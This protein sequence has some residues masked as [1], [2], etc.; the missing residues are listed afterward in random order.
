MQNFINENFMLQT[1]SAQKLY[2]DYAVNEPIFDYHCHLSPK[3]IYENP[4]YENLTELWLL[5]DHY[6][7]RLM[8]ACGISEEYITGNTAPYDKFLKWAQTI[9]KCIGNPLYIWT[10]LELKRYFG[11]DELLNSQTAPEI[12]EKTSKLL[13]Q[14]DGYRARDFITRSNVA[15]LCTTDDPIDT[16]E[17]HAAIKNDTS[18][19]TQVLPSFRPEVALHPENASFCDWIA[20]LGKISEFKIETMQDL[21]HA[22]EKRA[23]FFKNNG[24]LVADQSLNSPNFCVGTRDEAE[25]AFKKALSGKILDEEEYNCY[26]T[27]LMLS[28]GKIYK[29]LGFVMQLHFGVLRNT[30][31]RLFE[32]CGTDTG[33]DAV[34]DGVKAES[35]ST[36][37]DRL[38]KTN[39]LPKTVI[40]SLN[41]CD[42]DKLASVLGG[43]QEGC[44]PQKM[45]LGAPWW[46]SDHKDGMEKQMKALS[47]TGVLSGF[48]GMLTDSRSLL[49]Y[50]RHEYFR[51]VL[52]NLLGT[53]MENGEI[54]N[55]F[56]MVGG[57]V[58]NIC[59]NNVA[60]YFTLQK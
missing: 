10:H 41:A 19:K 21:E 35:I 2:S 30:N 15:A 12:W 14:K 3:E 22:L 59:F 26:Q 46:F 25:K 38:N 16:L 48:L 4:S 1:K 23:E 37:F 50:T 28:L 49:S 31:S 43:F 53:W 40:Y 54:P 6:K 52:C 45:Q 17:Y 27:Q 5:G 8:R 56:E 24:C 7:W 51:R 34:G 55:D 33:F 29:K 36:L 47:N 60:S 57:I 39:E 58:K 20:K 9:E 42:D 18:F 13:K 11:I 32:I 44:F